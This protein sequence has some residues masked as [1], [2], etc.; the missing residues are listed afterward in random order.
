MELQVL[1]M[2]VLDKGFVFFFL[3]FLLFTKMEI[4]PKFSQLEVPLGCLADQTTGQRGGNAYNHLKSA[5][6]ASSKSH[7]SGKKTG[8]G[9]RGC[10]R[11]EKAQLPLA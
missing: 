10:Q 1:P 3:F 6:S 4:E 11:K 5:P 2:G 9:G 8:G 7:F